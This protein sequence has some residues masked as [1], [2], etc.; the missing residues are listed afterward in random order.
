MSIDYMNTIMAVSQDSVDNRDKTEE[1]GQRKMGQTLSMSNKA[2][3]AR[4]ASSYKAHREDW[5]TKS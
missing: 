3:S 4:G 1:T 5:Y 2:T